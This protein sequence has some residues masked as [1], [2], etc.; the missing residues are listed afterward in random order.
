MQNTWGCFYAQLL[1]SS[2]LH[3]T[4]TVWKKHLGSRQGRLND[5]RLSTLFPLMHDRHEG[6][7]GGLI[8]F[9]TTCNTGIYSLQDHSHRRALPHPCHARLVY[10]STI[11]CMPCC[12][13]PSSPPFSACRSCC[14]TTSMF[15]WPLFLLPFYRLLKSCYVFTFSTS[16]CK[17]GFLEEHVEY[18]KEL[19]KIQQDKTIHS[20]H[21][22]NESM[23]E[24]MKVQIKTVNLACL[25]IWI[26][27]SVRTSVLTPLQ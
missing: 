3:W 27:R 7:W 8:L 2:S 12:L 6:C 24:S 10:P 19:L 15:A 22:L 25:L 9:W 13:I 18:W 26:I 21:S 4:L 17:I 11:C 16:Y 20:C 14:F 1:H 23:C 5:L